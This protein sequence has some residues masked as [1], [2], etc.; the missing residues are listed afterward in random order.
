MATTSIPLYSMSGDVITTF[1]AD[2]LAD[3]T[4][5]VAVKAM[6][7]DRCI[8]VP[9][10]RYD[11]ET[12]WGFAERY[13]L[14]IGERVLRGHEDTLTCINDPTSAGKR[15]MLYKKPLSWRQLKQKKH[16]RSAELLLTSS[17]TASKAKAKAKAKSVPGGEEISKGGK[18]KGRGG[19][20]KGKTNAGP[21]RADTYSGI[22]RLC[23]VCGCYERFATSSEEACWKRG[24]ELCRYFGQGR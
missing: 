18:G 10:A 9:G 5:D 13:F 2:E 11:E 22:G 17:S 21:R 1:T 14:V 8:G 12:Q 20:G 6:E 7:Q 3:C 4:V 15:L 16:R 24:Q 23:K 19:N